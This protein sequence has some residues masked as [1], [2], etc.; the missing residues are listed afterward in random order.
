MALGSNMQRSYSI[1]PCFIFV[2]LVIM[3]GTVLLAYYFECTDT[4]QVHVQGFFCQDGDLM[5]PYPGMEDESFIPPLVLYCVLA[6]TPTAIIFI[7]EISMYFIKTTRESLIVEE[8]TILTGECCYLNPLLRRI[9]RFIGVFAFGLFATDIFVNAGQVVTGNLAPYFLT[10][11]KPNY[12]GSDCRTHHQFVNNGNI[13]TGDQDVI[14]KARRS[15]PSKHAALSI[16]SAL[17]ATMYITSTIKTKS[18]RLAK[19]VLCLGT[20]CAAFLTGLNRVSEYRNHCSDVIAGF[21]LGSAV[22]LFL[23]ICVVHNFKGTHGAPSKSKPDEQRGMPLM[24]FPRV[25][26]PLETLSA[27]NHSASMTEVT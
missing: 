27:Q 24:A 12:T 8:K 19:P 22:A 7:G 13:C 10:V 18:S 3:A 14:E 23:G 4:F 9:I 1:I 20:L 2:E 6:A 5:K 21:I 25:E 16:Y 17:Y 11:C 26:S 15:F